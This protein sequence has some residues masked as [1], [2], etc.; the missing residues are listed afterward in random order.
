M[1]L[2]LPLRQTEGF[3]RSLADLLEAELPTPDHTTLSRRLRKLGAINFRWLATDRPIHL[4]ID[5]TGL[6]I[7][8][9]H[10]RKPPKRRVWRKLHLA[11]DAATGE[12]LAS[13]L[14]N[15]RTADRVR[16]GRLLDQIDGPLASVAA[17]GAY[18]AGS[19][20][21]AVQG[22]GDGHRVRV[23]IPPIQGAQPSSSRSPGQ[24]ERNRNIRSV[25]K[26]GRQEWYTSSGYSRRSL[27]ENAVFRYKNILGKRMRSRS[28]PSQRVEVKLACKILN[29]MTS[30]GRPDSVKVG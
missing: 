9:G 30:L 21:E 10:L 19:V 1:I 28:L 22:K 25:R 3:L 23:L 15:R 8:V 11:V 4:L 5:S 26:L 20:Y 24:W 27:V 14:T 16:V 2:H 6:R 18:D 12:V 17:D 29:T 13:D 7:H